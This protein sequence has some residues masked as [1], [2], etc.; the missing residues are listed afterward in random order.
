VT[1]AEHVDVPL[2]GQFEGQLDVC[3]V[4][5]G[6]SQPKAGFATAPG[7]GEFLLDHELP[8]LAQLRN[9]A[10]APSRQP[11]VMDLGHLE[12][13]FDEVAE[14]LVRRGNHPVEVGRSVGGKRCISPLR[15]S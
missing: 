3:R 1:P 12:F 7:K 8:G 4:D 14:F 5:D 11:M 6:G 2:D 13:A 10:C 15:R 9:K